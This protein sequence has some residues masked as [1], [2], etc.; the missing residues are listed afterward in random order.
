[1]TAEQPQPL[2]RSYGC[3][4]GCGNPYDVIVIM[5]SDGTT[6]FVCIPCFVKLA[7]DMVA[8]IVD[9]DD[10]NVKAAM[11]WASANPSESA[12]GPT[13]KR[14]KHN[15]PATNDDPDLLDA[16]DD[17][18]TVDDLPEEFRSDV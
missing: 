4:F 3:T 11:E 16:F 6:E 7:S 18:I 2:V 10:P 15:A 8:A 5:V 1:M 13:G 17:V 9:G 12:P 14:G